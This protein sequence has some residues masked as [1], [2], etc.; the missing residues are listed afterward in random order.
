MKPSAT[1]FDDGPYRLLARSRTALAQADRA[2]PARA[3]AAS[4]RAFLSGATR[5]SRRSVSGFSAGGL[6]RGRFVFSRP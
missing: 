4:Y 6:P 5:I 1:A 3:A 2:L